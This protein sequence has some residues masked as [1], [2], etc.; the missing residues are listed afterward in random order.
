MLCFSCIVD[1]SLLCHKIFIQKMLKCAGAYSERGFGDQTPPPFLRKIFN[2]LGFLKKKMPKP[3]LNFPVHTKKFLKPLLFKNLD[4][5]LEVWQQCQI[6]LPLKN[7]TRFMNDSKIVNL[8][9]DFTKSGMEQ[10]FFLF[11]RHVPS[12]IRYIAWLYAELFSS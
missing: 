11:L 3:P 10:H 1:P 12:G 9:F 8:F 2:L 5:P 6:P 4:T 7:W